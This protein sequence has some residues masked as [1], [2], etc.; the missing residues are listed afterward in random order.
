[1]M[2][3]SGGPVMAPDAYDNNI[4]LTTKTHSAKVKT[5]MPEKKRKQLESAKSVQSVEM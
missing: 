1:M 2:P 3:L 4:T 5:D